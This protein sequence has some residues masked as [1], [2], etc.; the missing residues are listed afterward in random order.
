MA[1]D[2]ECPSPVW[3]ESTSFSFNRP[4]VLVHVI[5]YLQ[6]LFIPFRYYEL[7]RVKLL[8]TKSCS[9]SFCA[10]DSR[11]RDDTTWMVYLFCITK[12]H[13]TLARFGRAL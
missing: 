7:I 8:N 3:S 6:R 11:T 5:S 10:A 13:I 1:R 4:M 12:N 2:L 9:G